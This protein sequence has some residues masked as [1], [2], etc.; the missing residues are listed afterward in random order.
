MTGIPPDPRAIGLPDPAVFG[1][2]HLHR[3]CSLPDFFLPRTVLL[4]AVAY[5]N[6]RAIVLILARKHRQQAATKGQCQTAGAEQSG[7]G[8]ALALPSYGGSVNGLSRGISVCSPFKYFSISSVAAEASSS[9]F[10]YWASLPW[11]SSWQG[12]RGN[13]HEG[14]DV[15]ADLV[16]KVEAGI[17]RTIPQSRG[18]AD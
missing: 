5:L 10:C 3:I 6:P 7:Q 14:A 2:L 15:G 1:I 9:R 13:L 4:T 16:S 18:K 11:L 17:P 12:W 8:Q